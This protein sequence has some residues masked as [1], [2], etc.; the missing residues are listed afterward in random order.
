MMG[1]G[2]RWLR[3]P[4]ARGASLQLTEVCFAARL[5]VQY[6]G[7]AAVQFKQSRACSTSGE[8]VQFGGAKHLHSRCVNAC[9]SVHFIKSAVG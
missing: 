4:S 8:C 3:L 2:R 5:L 9:S 6:M 7:N 1:P